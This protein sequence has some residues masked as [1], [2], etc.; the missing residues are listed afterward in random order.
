MKK[1]LVSVAQIEYI[2]IAIRTRAKKKKKWVSA[3]QF[4]TRKIQKTSLIDLV[5][6][7]VW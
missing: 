5:L 7:E 4:H 1:V 2:T 3:N 6:R